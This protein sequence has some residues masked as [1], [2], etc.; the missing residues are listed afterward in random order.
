MCSPS[1][2]LIQTAVAED[3][4]GSPHRFTHSTRHRLAWPGACTSWTPAQAFEPE[5]TQR[6][7]SKG[8]AMSL[9]ESHSAESQTHGIP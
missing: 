6:K 9:R 7:D 2:R 1:W 3:P 5:Q 8:A 4:G